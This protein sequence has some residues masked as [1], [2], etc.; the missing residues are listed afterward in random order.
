MRLRFFVLTS[1]SLQIF[2]PTELVEFLLLRHPEETHLP[3]LRKEF[4]TMNQN[5]SVRILKI[6][7]SRKLLHD[8]W[9]EIMV[10]YFVVVH[11]KTRWSKIL[12]NVLGLGG[13]IFYV[14]RP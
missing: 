6:F 5:A 4:L 14:F 2:Q 8:D 11:V 7:L 10:R 13:C 12:P 3:S 9:D 1:F